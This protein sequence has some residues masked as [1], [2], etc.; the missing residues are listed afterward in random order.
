MKCKDLEKIEKLKILQ[1]QFKR[2][3]IWNPLK[4]V[5]HFTI[6]TAWQWLHVP[7]MSSYANT[8]KSRNLAD[9]P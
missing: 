5:K 4:N 6:F 3:F 2:T 9:C 1:V 8:P 7:Y